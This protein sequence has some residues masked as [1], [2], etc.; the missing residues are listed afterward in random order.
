VAI[1]NQKAAMRYWPD[2]D[3]VGR[4]I[5]LDGENYEADWVTI[6]GVV[7]DFGCTVFGEPF[8]PALYIPHGQNPMPG[9]ELI[10]RAHGDPETAMESMRDIIRGMDAGIPVYS[11]RTVN[12]LVHTWLRDDRWLSYFLGGLAVLVLCLAC[13]GL[14]GIMSYAVVQRTNELGIRIA[15]GADRGE[16]LRL[17]IKGCLKVSSTGI[18][19]GLLLSIPVGLFMASYLYGVGGLDPLTY[20]G[21]ILLLLAVALAAGYLPARRAARI[22]PLLALMYE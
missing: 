16:I 5:L 8:P 3:A 18:L 12:D 15:M 4:Q 1:I 20:G 22:D 2:A 19:I 9:M 10:V 13:I 6:V 17:V 11:I 21:V 7:A 14:F